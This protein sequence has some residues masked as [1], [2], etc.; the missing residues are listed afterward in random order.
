MSCLELYKKRK[1]NFT[2]EYENLK[3]LKTIKAN[4]IIYLFFPL[5]KVYIT[6]DSHLKQCILN[7]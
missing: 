7:F 6:I 5:T 1:T 3:L 4:K 2:F